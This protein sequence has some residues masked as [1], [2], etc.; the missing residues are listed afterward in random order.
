MS[1][2]T[3][4]QVML[5]EFTQPQQNCFTDVFS[6]GIVQNTQRHLDIRRKGHT[7][8]AYLNISTLFVLLS[9][10]Q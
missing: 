7:V 9:L 5:I 8:T 1:I 10:K 6:S 3:V 2:E 4:F